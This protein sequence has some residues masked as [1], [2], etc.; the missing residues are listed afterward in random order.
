[1]IPLAGIINFNHVIVS[2]SV[3]CSVVYQGGRG[4]YGKFGYRSGIEIKV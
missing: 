2:D 3:K 4:A 1:M